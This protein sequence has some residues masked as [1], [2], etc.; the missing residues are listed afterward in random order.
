MRRRSNGHRHGENGVPRGAV[1]TSGTPHRSRAPA[2]RAAGAALPGDCRH[3][4]PPRTIAGIR[5]HRRP[6]RPRS[7]ATGEFPAPRPGGGS[8][9]HFPA[10]DDQRPHAGQRVC[11]G[12]ARLH[13]GVR[14]HPAHQLRAR[15]SGDDRGD[16]RVLGHHRARRRAGRAA[17]ARDPDRRRAG[18]GAGLHGG[19]LHA[20][21]RR[22]PAAAQR[23]AARAADHGDRPVDH[24]AAP[25]DDH[26]EPQP[27]AVPADRHGHVVS[28]SPATPT[29]RRSPMCRS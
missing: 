6:G 5:A 16:G 28:T 24:P 13:D 18:R 23:A 17:T 7:A 12:R 27:D 21:A 8:C 25:G 10:A 11:G 26:L 19:R 15:R 22:L 29:A 9:G 3:R 1:F 20:G 2:P 4:A 14:D